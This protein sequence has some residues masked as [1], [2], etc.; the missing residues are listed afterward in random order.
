[1]ST[2]MNRGV[3]PPRTLPRTDHLKEEFQFLFQSYR[4]TAACERLSSTAIVANRRVKYTIWDTTGKIGVQGDNRGGFLK[5]TKRLAVNPASTVLLKLVAIFD[6]EVEL[7]AKNCGQ[8][9]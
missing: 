6:Q 7:V 5:V 1:M 8:L 3:G 4:A 9:V 2:E